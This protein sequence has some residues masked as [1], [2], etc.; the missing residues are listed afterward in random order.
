MDLI[1]YNPFPEGAPKYIRA[2]LYHYHFTTPNGRW[3]LQCLVS[4]SPF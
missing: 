3:I 4:L 1:E 2:Q